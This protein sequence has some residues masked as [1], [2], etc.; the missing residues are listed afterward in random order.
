MRWLGWLACVFVSLLKLQR[1]LLYR[2]VLVRTPL[3][4]NFIYYH[5]RY[6]SHFGHGLFEQTTTKTTSKNNNNV[7]NDVIKTF[8]TTLL[9]TKTI[10]T[11]EDEKH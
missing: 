5:K 11:N 9:Q 8:L 10:H 1:F 3:G 6:V 4:S 2:H 7:D